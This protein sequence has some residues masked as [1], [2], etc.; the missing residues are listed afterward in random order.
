M[1]CVINVSEKEAIKQGLSQ[2][3]DIVIEYDPADLSQE[4]REEMALSGTRYVNGKEYLLANRMYIGRSFCG[5]GAVGKADIDSLRFLLDLR[6]LKRAAIAHEEQERVE[7]VVSDFMNAPFRQLVRQATKNKT[8]QLQDDFLDKIIPVD[9]EYRFLLNDIYR[10]A[11]DLPFDIRDGFDGLNERIEQIKEE[12][13]TVM[14]EVL[15]LEAQHKEDMERIRKEADAKA[16]QE[17]EERDA[18]EKVAEDERRAWI[19]EHGSE[20]LKLMADAGYEYR[21]TYEEERVALEFPGYSLMP[22]DYDLDD[23]AN[24]S[25]EA[26]K[27]LKRLKA[28]DIEAEIRWI[29]GY[30]AREEKYE[31]IVVDVPWCRKYLIKKTGSSDEAEGE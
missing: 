2:S 27:E 3:G 20:R 4:Q 8:S 25:L 24:P 10:K 12:S 13:A 9:E 11:V 28:L 30:D 5:E 1:K 17:K 18:A 7:K 14:E 26:L 22:E 15:K 29:T 21:M 31:A 16:K 23:R 19:A 6:I